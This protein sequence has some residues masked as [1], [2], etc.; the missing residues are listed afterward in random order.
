MEQQNPPQTP[1]PQN[2]SPADRAGP[3]VDPVTNPDHGQDGQ[4]SAQSAAPAAEQW[5]SRPA[6]RPLLLIIAI[7]G[8]IAV[9]LFAL[10]TCTSGVNTAS[11]D[12]D[13][14]PA[15]ILERNV[16]E[17]FSV[18]GET[19]APQPQ[20]QPQTTAPS[21]SSAAPVYTPAE[22]TRQEQMEALQEQ[23]QIQQQQE[24]MLQEQ[25]NAV[26]S[27]LPEKPPRP[28]KLGPY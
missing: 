15:Q 13:V 4:Y 27:V 3:L 22:Q 6:S 25:R 16:N 17:A 23:Q 5:D 21:S 11:V 7:V 2:Q 24:Q 1:P 19:S 10:S 9:I 28:A 26:P 20:P 14:A 8:V 18:D 12:N